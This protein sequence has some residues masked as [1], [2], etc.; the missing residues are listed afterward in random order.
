MPGGDSQFIGASSRFT[1]ERYNRRSM[2]VVKYL[3]GSKPDTLTHARAERLHY[4]LFDSEFARISLGELPAVICLSLFGRR[5]DLF[6]EACSRQFLRER[7]KFNEVDAKPNH[8][9]GAVDL[10]PSG[11]RRHSL[12][13]VI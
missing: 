4:R 2:F 9:H 1:V 11:S 13:S 12:E 3:N 10:V 7:V 6:A 8:V 5:E